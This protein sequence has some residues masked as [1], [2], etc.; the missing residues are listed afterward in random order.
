MQ[1]LRKKFV[2]V[3]SDLGVA[4]CQ[5]WHQKVRHHS[6]IRTQNSG[7]TYMPTYFRHLNNY[8]ECYL[9]VIYS[10]KT[11][12][13][14]IFKLEN[15]MLT[16]SGT[17]VNVGSIIQDDDFFRTQCRSIIKDDDVFRSFLI[18]RKHFTA[19]NNCSPN[20]SVIKYSK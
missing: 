5:N 15:L 8:C 17:N 3:I 10:N 12:K 4:V 7:R 2:K 9:I 11:P 18:L 16:R 13:F 20:K 6:N 1:N 14:S 19:P